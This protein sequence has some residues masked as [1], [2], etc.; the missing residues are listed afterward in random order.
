[1]TTLPES[2][3]APVHPELHSQVDCKIQ[4]PSTHVRCQK[5]LPLPCTHFLLP[6][7]P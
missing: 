5:H 1:M 7:L 3:L 2:Q 6:Q 4:C